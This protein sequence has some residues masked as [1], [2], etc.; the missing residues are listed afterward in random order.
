VFVCTDIST[1]I[2]QQCTEYE[3]N[4]R[5]TNPSRRKLARKM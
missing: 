3:V 4:S 2:V 1:R 5:D